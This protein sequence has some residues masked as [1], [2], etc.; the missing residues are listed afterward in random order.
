MM[1]AML[2]ACVNGTSLETMVINNP[3]LSLEIYDV[4]TYQ[5]GMSVLVTGSIRQLVLANGPIWG[6]STLFIRRS[7][8]ARQCRYKMGKL[9]EPR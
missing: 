7:T 3:N 8:A 6:I 4:R 2:T 5:H 1:L 9:T